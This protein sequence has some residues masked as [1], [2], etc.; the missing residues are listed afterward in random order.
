MEFYSSLDR[1][2]S[3]PGQVPPSWRSVISV[4]SCLV[5][6]CAAILFVLAPFLA[7]QE[8]TGSA[9]GD[10]K[11]ATAAESKNEYARIAKP[12]FAKH[13]VACHSPKNSEGDLDLTQL[14][15]DMKESSSGARWAMVV[16]KLTRGEMPPRDRPRPEAESLAGVVRWAHAEAKRAGKHF[17]RRAAHVNGN[18]VSHKVLF[19]PKNIP[20]YQGDPRVRRLS[21]EIYKG[22]LKDHGNIKGTGQPF[23]PEGRNTFKDMGAP[24]IDEPVTAQ[25][26]QNALLIAE[27]QTAHKIEGEKIKGIGNVP[28]EFLALLDPKT[29]PSDQQIEAAVALQ[30]NTILKRQPTDA[31]QKRFAGL[32]KK[33]IADAGPIHGV[34]YGLAAVL[35]LPEAVFRMEVGTGKADEKGRVRLA[36]REIAFALA[37]ALTDKRPDAKLLTT[38]ATGGLDNDE[39]VAKEVRRMLDDPKADNP[40]ILRFFQEYFEYPKAVDVFKET[41]GSVVHLGHD[42]KVLVED[43]DKLVLYLFEQDKEVL[44]ELLTTNKSFVAI[45]S[46]STFAQ[47]RKARVDAIAKFEAEKAKNPERYKNRTL[48]LPGKAIYESYGLKDF[49]DV[50]PVE[51]PG[52]QRA[53]I[54]TQPS[55]LVAF[56]TTFDNHAIFRGK[57]VRER[58]LGN[59]VPDLPVTVDAQL[60]DAPE[61]TLRERMSVTKE[62]FCWKCHRFMN[63]TGLPFEQFDGFGRFR[64]T[65]RVVDPEATAKNVDGK[66]KSKGPLFRDVAV[67]TTGSIAHVGDPSLEGD[68]KNPIEF[69][70]KLAGSERVEQVFVRHAFRYW[71]GRNETPGDAGSL[72]AAHKAYRA[73]QGSMKALITALLASESFLYRVPVV[74]EKK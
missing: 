62:E 3:G 32:M 54:M 68:V 17:S 45:K 16:E 7:G 59:A 8:K 13:C 60:P 12:F 35:L 14:D 18:L 63:N 66:G 55:W 71:L 28:K 5:V 4:F 65:E 26:L 73:N 57:W 24:T 23:S 30:F 58:L 64:T 51:L 40:R 25:L 42:P 67:D 70:K 41:T 9:T 49:P 39:G 69:V 21:P 56:S 34:R 61:K 74:T 50:Q 22:F 27:N 19:D 31:E 2:H 53:G 20:P 48:Q 46:A 37:Y 44:R 11:F 36:P 10:L 43:T 47:F 1:D 72:Q 38:A 15:P 33:T 52:D 6:G 29:P